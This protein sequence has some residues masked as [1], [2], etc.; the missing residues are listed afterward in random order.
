MTSLHAREEG[1][2]R[3]GQAGRPVRLAAELRERIRAA[4]DADA[5]E[6]ENV[7]VELVVV[8]Q[9]RIDRLLAATCPDGLTARQ[10]LDHVCGILSALPPETS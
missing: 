9:A 10:R 1:G 5:R 3:A 4:I 6:R 8:D 7:P 2:A